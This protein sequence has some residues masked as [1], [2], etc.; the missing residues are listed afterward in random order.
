MSIFHHCPEDLLAKKVYFLHRE[1]V[2]SLD[3]SLMG[4]PNSTKILSIFNIQMVHLQFE[5]SFFVD[6]SAP[7]L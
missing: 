2:F 5:F 3:R 4:N 6:I 7:K 1:G